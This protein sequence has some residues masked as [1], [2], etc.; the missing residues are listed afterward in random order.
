[1]VCFTIP[2]NRPVKATKVTISNGTLTVRQGGYLFGDSGDATAIPTTVAV[3]ALLTGFGSISVC[4]IFASSIG[5]T[6]NSPVGITFTGKLT[7]S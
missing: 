5:G 7:F 4:V 2:L 1:M 6:N 3:K